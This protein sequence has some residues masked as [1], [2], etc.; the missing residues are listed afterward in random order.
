MDLPPPPPPPLYNHFLWVIGESNSSLIKICKLLK[1]IL[2][3][4]APFQH[5]YRSSVLILHRSFPNIYNLFFT[6]SKNSYLVSISNLPIRSVI[7]LVPDRRLFRLLYVEPQPR[8]LSGLKIFCTFFK[9]RI[10]Y[11]I[12]GYLNFN[13]R[14]IYA[15]RGYFNSKSRIINAIMGYFSSKT[16]LIYAFWG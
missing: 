8:L 4:L 14:I 7:T 2:T 1:T 3:T 9:P 10:I 12:R 13:S 16:M 5:G 15:I 6:S 11:A